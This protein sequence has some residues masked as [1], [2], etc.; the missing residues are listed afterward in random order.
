MLPPAFRQE[1]VF[2]LTYSS[3][4]LFIHP[5][6]GTSNIP[7]INPSF[8]PGTPPSP[9]FTTVFSGLK[10]YTLIS[11]P[12]PHSPCFTFERPLPGQLDVPSHSPQ[13]QGQR[14]EDSLVRRVRHDANVKRQRLPA[15]PP[16][17]C[18]KVLPNTTPLL[19]SRTPSMRSPT[20]PTSQMTGLQAS[21][22][23]TVRC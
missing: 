7:T 8:S 22:V 21:L 14:C 17:T 16:H 19:S 2:V 11:P 13:L 3:G 5:G 9:P 18:T 12:T 20:C 1:R 15:I 10:P 6:P 23:S 4:S